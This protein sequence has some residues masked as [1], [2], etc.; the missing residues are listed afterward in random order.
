MSIL[1]QTASDLGLIATSTNMDAADTPFSR[2]L[3]AA[4]EQQPLAPRAG[5]GRPNRA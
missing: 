5:V 3:A 2:P 1:G 4:R